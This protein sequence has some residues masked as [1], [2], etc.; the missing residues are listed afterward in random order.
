[1]YRIP[2]CAASPHLQR[3]GQENSIRPHADG[4]DGPMS[5]QPHVM[6]RSVGYRVVH[7]HIQHDEGQKN[8]VVKMFSFVRLTLSSCCSH[9]MP[10]HDQDSMW[11]SDVLIREAILWLKGSG[12]LNGSGKLQILYLEP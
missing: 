9:A 4:E 1:M 6:V 10:P 2:M 8:H 3:R 7:Q 11:T 5:V 12:A